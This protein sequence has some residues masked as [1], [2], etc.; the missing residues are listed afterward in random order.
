MSDAKVVDAA[1]DWYMA[2]TVFLKL[3]AGS[4]ET[5]WHLDQLANAEDALSK[6]VRDGIS[7]AFAKRIADQ[8]PNMEM[9][10]DHV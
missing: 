2:R 8:V 3:P 4:P 9:Q 5:R 10:D 6:A 7:N 1:I